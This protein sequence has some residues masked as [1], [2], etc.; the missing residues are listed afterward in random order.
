MLDAGSRSEGGELEGGAA[1]GE[2]WGCPT[3][4]QGTA[5]GRLF[6]RLFARRQCSRHGR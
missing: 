5:A 1:I 2:T 4:S 3:V 6:I